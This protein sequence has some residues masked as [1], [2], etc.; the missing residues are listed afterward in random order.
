VSWTPGAHLDGAHELVVCVMRRDIVDEYE[1]ACVR[2]NAQAGIVDI[3]TFNLVNLA[4]AADRRAGRAPTGGDWL[5]V[6]LTQDYSA[7]AIVRD[8]ALI[9]YRY[10]PAEAEEPLA[11]LVHQ[12]SM[13]YEDRLGGHGLSRV[14][15]SG[16]EAADAGQ[17]EALQRAVAS[18]WQ[19]ALEPLDAARAA[20]VTDRITAASD[21]LTAMA[22]AVGLVLREA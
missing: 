19:C 10:R 7:L 14:V 5:L 22:P 13:Y 9:F 4:L 17:L 8:A 21:L 6:S 16:G 11:D 18:R 3:A 12:A 2:H 20:P 1:A 15:I